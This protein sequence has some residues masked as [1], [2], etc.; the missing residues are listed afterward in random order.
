MQ[1]SRLITGGARLSCA[2]L[3]C[4]LYSVHPTYST[5]VSCGT[6]APKVVTFA[7]GEAAVSVPADIVEHNENRG[8]FEITEFHD[9]A[10]LLMAGYAGNFPSID[11][12][13]QRSSSPTKEHLGS[14]PAT[15]YESVKDGRRTRDTII[16]VK[17][18]GWPMFVHFFYRQ[19]PE[20]RA[21]L[22]DTIICSFKFTSH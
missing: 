16:S 17:E 21:F 2:L 10:G 9:S 15:T 3:L 14:F 6:A 13:S 8:D 1:I 11:D 20:E 5:A 12:P 4:V 22:A 19:L 18:A 7:D